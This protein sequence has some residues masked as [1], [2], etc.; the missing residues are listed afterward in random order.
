MAPSGKYITVTNTDVA[1]KRQLFALATNS[2]W[3]A[4]KPQASSQTQL[5]TTVRHGLLNK[6]NKAARGRQNGVIK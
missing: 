1:S 4:R 2:S 5:A 3:P 6:K